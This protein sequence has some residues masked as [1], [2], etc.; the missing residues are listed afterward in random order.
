[1]NDAAGLCCCRCRACCRLRRP[2]DEHSEAADPTSRIER[3]EHGLLPRSQSRVSR[4]R[5]TTSRANGAL[6]RAA[7]GIA[8]INEGRSNGRGRTV[9]SKRATGERR[10]RQHS[11]RRRRSRSR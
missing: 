6:R 8:V 7:V 11:S 10:T 2:L 9:F 1:M 4:Y 3:V 5:A